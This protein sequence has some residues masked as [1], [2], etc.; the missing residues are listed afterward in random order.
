MLLKHYLIIVIFAAMTTEHVVTTPP[1]RL[2][3]VSTIATRKRIITWMVQDESVHGHRSLCMRT[4]I[5]FS[6]HFRGQRSANLVRASRWWVQID[7]FCNEGEQEIESTPISCCRGR[8]GG[9]KQLRTKAAS[10][11][12]H[13][14]SEW[15][16][17]LYPIL[18]DAFERFKKSG[19]KLSTRF[20]IELAMTSLLDLTSPYTILSRDPKD[21]V[22]L[23]EKLTNN[24][25]LC[26]ILFFYHKV[27]V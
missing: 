23:I 10:G 5:E 27:G 6:E 7:K 4:I 19:V 25:C 16:Q 21:N 12:G 3:Q 20:L 2:Q 9:L 24:S 15:V 8:S 17:W 13:K 14:R 22:L 26:I 18:L 11:R 1:R